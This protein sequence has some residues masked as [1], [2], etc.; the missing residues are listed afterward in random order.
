MISV[1]STVLPTPAPPILAALGE[2][3]LQQGS[4]LNAGL[5]ANDRIKYAFSLLQMAIEHARHPEQPAASLKRERLAA[6][7]DDAQYDA[8]IVGA[9]AVGEEVRIPGSSHILERIEA[10]RS[11]HPPRWRRPWWRAL[12]SQAARSR[13]TQ[14][15]SCG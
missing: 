8:T 5:A 7:I 2:S 1:R 3:G 6:G 11:R 15:R 14:P 13:S 4:A 9:L 12:G 10:S